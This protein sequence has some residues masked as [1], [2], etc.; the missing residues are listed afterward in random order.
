[1]GN[2]VIKKIVYLIEAAL[3][4]PLCISNGDGELT[5]QDVIKNA[6]GVPFIPG[7]S[8][9][10]AMRGYLQKAADEDCI[11]GYE[12]YQEIGKMSSVY[13]S[14]FTFLDHPKIQVRDSVALS[15]KKTAITGAKFD[16]EVV[17]TGAKGYFYLEMVIRA[18]DHEKEMEEQLQ[19]V[20]AG[21]KME[22]IRLGAK[23]TRGYGELKLI[24]V[25]EK[26]FTAEN[27]M[28]YAKVYQYEKRDEVFGKKSIL[29]EIV[30]RE[31]SRYITLT[32]PLKQ[33]GGISIRQYSVKKGEP[34][35]VHITAGGKPVIPG[36]SMAGAV[37]HRIKDLLQQLEICNTK[38]IID[39]IFGLVEGKKA[40]KS[41]VIF[42]ECILEGAE[43]LTMVRNGVSRFESGT[44]QGALFKEVSYVGGTTELKI[45]VEQGEEAPAMIGILLLALKDLSGGYLAVGGQTAVG[46]G[47]FESVGKIQIIGAAYT[48]EQCFKEA[49]SA[50]KRKGDANA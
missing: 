50:L 40:R 32:L 2:R 36:T 11:F 27:I 1:M 26:T 12:K 30:L 3:A 4:S 46:R 20:L 25:K 39:G 19:N 5:D 34:D 49:Y 45:K 13:V 31:N 33:Q 15:D 28:D 17:D 43:M 7:S 38:E 18:R 10:G 47:L 37:R 44:K 35:F 24:A 42:N 22:D 48:E 8:L 9:V 23:K 21:W 14:D 6:E 29:D 41:S 16:M